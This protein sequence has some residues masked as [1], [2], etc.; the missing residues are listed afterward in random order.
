[1]GPDR[2]PPGRAVRR[3]PWHRRASCFGGLAIAALGYHSGGFGGATNAPS[4]HAT[5]PPGNALVARHF[6]QSTANPANLIFRYRAARSGT[7]RRR[8]HAP[9]PRCAPRASS[10][11]STGRSSPTARP[12]TPAQLRGA[13]RELLGDPPAAASTPP[14]GTRVS[15]ADY[16]AYRATTT[17]RQCRR[18]DRSSSRPRCA[19]AASRRPRRST[20]RRRSADAVDAAATRSRATD[21]GV[22]GEAAALYDVSATSNHDLR[23]TSSRSRSSRS[24]LLLALVL[25]SL[26]APLYLIVSVVFSYL[27][28]LG[29]STLVFIDIGG[30]GG[31][32]FILPFLMFIFLL[33]LGEDYN[34]L[35]MTRIRE[36]AQHAA[37]CARPSSAP[38]GAPARRSPRPGLVLAGTFGVL[39]VA[40]RRRR[41]GSQIRDDR[42]SGSPSASSWTPSSSARCSSPPPSPCSAAGTGGRRRWAGVTPAAPSPRTAA[43][44]SS[45]RQAGHRLTISDHIRRRQGRVS[46]RRRAARRRRP[47]PPRRRAAR[48]AASGRW[49]AARRTRTG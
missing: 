43:Q 6:P 5:P 21:G 36:E 4:G 23:R 13:A 3:S 44:P 22:A 12:L 26:V 46:L 37:R 39:A 45:A 7:T 35:V 2:G 27:A 10:R 30:D 11:R 16:N 38:S 32:T 15:T 19:P 14:R 25:R 41:L 20:P 8:R 40:G 47:R 34:I 28:A 31:L 17:V 33:A 18:P 9:R 49:L 24:A 1:M 42:R 48:R 29:V